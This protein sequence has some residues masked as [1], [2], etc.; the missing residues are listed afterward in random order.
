MPM[1]FQRA[2]RKQVRIKLAM[3]GPSGSGKTLGALV[4]ARGL[5]GPSGRIALIDTEN[6]S[7]SLYANDFEFDAL[8]LEAP[9]T[10]EQYMEAVRLA[11]AGQYDV[12][13]IDSL[14]HAW[15]GA[16]GILDRK[17]TMDAGGGNSFANW[18][19]FSK[20]HGRFV[21]ELMSAPTMLICTMRS[22]Q[23]YVV[24]QN[25]RGRQ[26]PKKLG[27]A[28]VQREGLD[29]EFSVVFEVGI[30]HIARAPKDRTGL[31]EGREFNL[32]DPAI[33]AEIR[34]WM[35]EGKADA[36]APERVT[37]LAAAEVYGMALPSKKWRGVPLKD[38]PDDVLRSAALYAHE[39]PDGMTR[40]L[41]LQDAIA[42]VLGDREDKA[43]EAQRAAAAAQRAVSAQTPPAGVSPEQIQSHAAARAAD[44][45]PPLAG[46]VA[47]RS[48]V[49]PGSTI[50]AVPVTPEGIALTPEWKEPGDS[51]PSMGEKIPG[52]DAVSPE[53][54]LRHQA[55]TGYRPDEMDGLSPHSSADDAEQLTQLDALM[56]RGG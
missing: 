48:L 2:E 24:E 16:G 46:S 29:Y 28:A 35:S 32:R 43:E 11:V 17:E 25:S 55:L 31:F 30:D 4:L 9:Y 37:T 50:E 8:D 19:K 34:K 51:G 20:E 40:L 3:Q 14:S 53:A 42:L 39:Q 12:I 36:A 7:A 10:T 18:A 26:E 45:D 1:Q 23:E 52:L 38:I 21:A 15:V 27:M 47:I 6:R 22:K 54:E 13:I 41:P 44:G 49:P 5:V 33:A 56:G